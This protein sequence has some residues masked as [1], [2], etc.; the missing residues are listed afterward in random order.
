[1]VQ[2]TMSSQ[3]QPQPSQSDIASMQAQLQMLQQLV[4]DLGRSVSTGGAAST[5]QPGPSASSSQATSYSL[6]FS[7]GPPNARL[8]SGPSLGLAPLPISQPYQSARQ[9]SL[10]FPSTNANVASASALQPILGMN[11]LNVL[12]TGRVN[13]ARLSHSAGLSIRGRRRPRGLAPVLPRLPARV[14]TAESCIIE[15]SDPPMIRIT[16]KVFPPSVS[17]ASF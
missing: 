12:G 14:E 17:F 10:T 3:Q 8:G 9:T 16:A 6:P 13:E 1:M 7:P 5:A 4:G 11:R 2:F 15:G